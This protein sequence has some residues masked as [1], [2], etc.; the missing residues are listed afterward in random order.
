MPH[1]LFERF[2]KSEK[3]TERM[4][5]ILSIA[6]EKRRTILYAKFN[7]RCSSHAYFGNYRLI[8]A[9]YTN[10]FLLS[11][12]GLYAIYVFRSPNIKAWNGIGIIGDAPYHKIKNVLKKSPTCVRRETDFKQ[13]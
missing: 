3:L 13:V 5:A 10:N 11:Y 12:N 9:R 1:D 4:R 8:P 7:G 2:K 6:I